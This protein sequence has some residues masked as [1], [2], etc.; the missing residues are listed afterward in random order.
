MGLIH[1]NEAEFNAAQEIA[2]LWEG[3]AFRR[4]IE[5]LETARSCLLLH[6]VYFGR[7]QG[8]VYE[9]SGDAVG[10]EGIDLVFHQRDE[11]RHNQGEAAEA[12]RR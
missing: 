8:A 9:G 7:G 3:Q 11:R 5:Q 4:R 6:A 2:E 1:G 10:I 12:Q